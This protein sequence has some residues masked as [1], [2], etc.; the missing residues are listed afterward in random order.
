MSD[1]L[2]FTKLNL[3]AAYYRAEYKYIKELCDKS[4][5]DLRRFIKEEHPDQYDAIFSPPKNTKKENRK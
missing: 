5:Q 4:E 2:K 1:N 3:Q